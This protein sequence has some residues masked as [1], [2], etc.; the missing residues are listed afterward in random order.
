MDVNSQKGTAAKVYAKAETVREPFLKRGRKAAELTIPSL[1]PPDDHSGKDNLAVPN[2]SIGARGVNTLSAKL[3]L[4][5]MPP[6]SPFFQFKIDDYLLEEMTQ[7][8][9]MRAT[10][11]ET[12]GKIERAIY[13]EIT[14]K[15]MDVTVGEALKQLIVSGNTLLYLP[16]EGGIKYFRLNRY[17]IRRD[18]MGNVL[19]LV[20][21]E[22]ISP[23]LL[24]ETFRNAYLKDDADQASQAQDKTVDIYTHV[25][26]ED[27]GS[28]TVYQEVKGEIVPGS[29]GTYP[30]GKS[31][32]VPLRFTE[33]EGEDYGRGYIEEYYGDLHS[34]DSL[35]KAVVEGS[36]AAARLVLFVN[37]N[38]V[39]KAED[40]TKTKN[41]G[42][43]SGRA[44]DVTLLQLQKYADF[45]TAK[46][47]LN[48]IIQRLS[49][50]FLLNSAVQRGG[51][52]VTAEEIRYV[53]SELEDALGGIYSILSQEL[54]LPL[55]RTILHQMTKQGKVP[56]LPDSVTPTI[57]TGLEALGRGHDLQRLDVFL[58]GARQALGDQAIVSRLNVGDYLTRRGTALG[59]DM[60]GLIKSDEQVQ[61]EQAEAQQS[62]MD[63]LMQQTMTQGGMDMVKDASK[64]MVKGGMKPNE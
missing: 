15:A 46:E 45:R 50:A 28:W 38:G 41:G 24:P 52:R 23:T 25:K 2:Q 44:D 26:L 49:Y 54:Q 59:I 43:A 36:M 20:I 19:E 34:A 32:W 53:A 5:L 55:V 47:T 16:P 42:V 51:E 18:P 10:V 48:D 17:I 64:E 58:S 27:K 11:E 61:Q 3:L 4:T 56:A 39:T 57:T 62:Q 31:P 21:K 6:N 7:Q 13:G 14:A 12:L 63:E 30:K 35:Q 8:E 9:G 29:E 40:V 22:T 37:P 1:L 60:K 33:I